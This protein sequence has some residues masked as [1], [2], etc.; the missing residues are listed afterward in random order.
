MHI[1]HVSQ[2]WQKCLGGSLSLTQSL[3][4]TRTHKLKAKQDEVTLGSE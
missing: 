3:S 1:S 4:H 2:K